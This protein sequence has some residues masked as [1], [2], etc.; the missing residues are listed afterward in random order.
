MLFV[1]VSLCS[2]ENEDYLPFV[3]ELSFIVVT[4]NRQCVNITVVDDTV[5][6]NDDVFL[7]EAIN[8]SVVTP[9][10]SSVRVTIIND[11]SK[12]IDYIKTVLSL[13]AIIIYIYIYIYFFFSTAAFVFFEQSMIAVNESVGRAQVCVVCSELPEREIVISLNEQTGTAQ[14]TIIT[15]H[16]TFFLYTLNYSS[17]SSYT[18]SEF[19]ST[20]ADFV[21]VSNSTVIMFQSGLTSDTQCVDIEIVNDNILESSE[22]FNI[23]LSSAD[24]DVAIENSMASIVIL[25]DD[26]NIMPGNNHKYLCIKFNSHALYYRGNCELQ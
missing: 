21:L 9:A 4:D 14:G 26:G 17:N 1:F 5:L 25:D 12:C 11:D 13:L 3:E 8:T 22:F 15:H 10:Q 23:I 24:P 7:I 2:I 16:Q 18:N 6:E 19:I 20:A